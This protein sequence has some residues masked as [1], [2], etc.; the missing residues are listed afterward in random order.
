MELLNEHGLSYN[1]TKSEY[2]SMLNLLPV[3]SLLELRKNLFTRA[4]KKNLAD[5]KVSLVSRRDTAVHPLSKKL[6]DDVWSLTSC[7]KHCKP[8]PR[9]LLK[10]GKRCKSFSRYPS[11]QCQVYRHILY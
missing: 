6:V 11:G 10:N 8:V 7:L 2:Q 3:A 4:V 9:V 5:S 1:S